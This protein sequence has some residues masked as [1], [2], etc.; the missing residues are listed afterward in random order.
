[1]GARQ[2]LLIRTLCAHSSH[3]IDFTIPGIAN[4]D[5]M[6]GYGTSPSM[7]PLM[8][9]THKIDP[10]RVGIVM[11]TACLIPGMVPRTLTRRTES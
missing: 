2:I 6:Y 5:M 8:L 1:M 11:R 9:A 3:E 7:R 4:F 10:E